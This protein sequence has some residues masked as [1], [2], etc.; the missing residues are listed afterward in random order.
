[1]G[2]ILEHLEDPVKGLKEAQ[3]VAKKVVIT[4]PFEHEWHS[5]IAIPFDTLEK[6]EKEL[7]KPRKE[8]Y[9][10]RDDCIFYKDDNYEHLRHR[11][12]YTFD[13]LVEVLKESGAKNY[14]IKRL[15]FAGLSYFGVVI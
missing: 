5:G 13:T 15:R 1:M 6:E 2:E 11:R 10:D 3:R 14:L 9:K 12:W 8:F 7:G 4:V